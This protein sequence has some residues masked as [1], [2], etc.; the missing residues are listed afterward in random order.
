[1]SVSFC[2]VVGFLGLMIPHAVRGLFGHNIA[3]QLVGSPLLGA[4]ALILFDLTARTVL[5]H[6]GELPVGIIT[7]LA[8]GIFFFM[9]IMRRGGRVWGK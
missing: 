1:M 2:G 3:M 9:L 5:P 7:S 6:G 8:G 4:S